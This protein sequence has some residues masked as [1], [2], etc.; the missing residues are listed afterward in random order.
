MSYMLCVDPADRSGSQQLVR[1]FFPGNL[2]LNKASSRYWKGS[3]KWAQLKVKK[4]SFPEN[5]GS[6]SDNNAVP[7]F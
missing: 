5:C 4:C 2:E 6:S 1:L 3:G 7:G